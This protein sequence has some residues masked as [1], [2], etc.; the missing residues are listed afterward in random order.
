MSIASVAA[1]SLA[2][3]SRSHRYSRDP[4]ALLSRAS[5]RGVRRLARYVASHELPYVDI[6][7]YRRFAD[8]HDH[9]ELEGFLGI[10]RLDPCV[11]QLI[12]PGDWVI[13]I[14]ANVGLIT[15]QMCRLVGPRGSVWAVEPI[16][17]NIQRLHELA[18]LNLLPQ[19]KI[20]EGALS[21]VTGEAS[22]RLPTGHQSGWASFTASWITGGSLP[23]PT[24]RLDDLVGP[25]SGRIRL[26]KLDVEG[27]ELQ[28]L[29]GATRTLNSMRPHV[30]CEFNDIVLKDAGAS[31]KELLRVFAELGYRPSPG[32]LKQTTQL[33]GQVVDLLME[34]GR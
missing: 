14:G 34:F 1:E 2:R 16:P 29:A 5:G 13:D 4:A 21:N 25:D 8:I 32:C 17:R 31:S 27:F 7:G 28:V 26:I 18:N 22:I 6:S 11:A 9:I 23:T 24:W 15:S 20:I 19:L 30:M 33:E 12:H 10:G 3:I